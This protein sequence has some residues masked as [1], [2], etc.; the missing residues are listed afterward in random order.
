MADDIENFTKILAET[1]A[2]FTNEVIEKVENGIDKIAE[3]TKAE[4]MANSPVSAKSSRKRHYKSKW[5]TAKTRT[6]GVYRVTVHNTNYQL[7]HLLELGHL[8][9]DGTTRSRAF[10]HVAP[11]ESNAETKI[12]RL[13]EGV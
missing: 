5:K 8:N 13:L 12:D 6:K 9:R 7:V 2:T 3:E 11:A 10:P 4:V 1:C